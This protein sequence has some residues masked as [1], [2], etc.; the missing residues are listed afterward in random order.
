MSLCSEKRG[1][2][3]YLA[4]QRYQSYFSPE[5]CARVRSYIGRAGVARATANIFITVCQILSGPLRC[6]TRAPT[7]TP[8]AL[9]RTDEKSYETAT[10]YARLA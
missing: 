1:G 6:Y 9:R 4:P 5:Q 2:G 10:R 8:R 3:R 7:A